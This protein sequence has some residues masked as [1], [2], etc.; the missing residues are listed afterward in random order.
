LSLPP[1]IVHAPYLT[2]AARALAADRAGS[3]AASRAVRAIW[4][5]NHLA[6]GIE[7]LAGQVP[8]SK[9]PEDLLIAIVGMEAELLVTLRC[10]RVLAHAAGSHL[11][12]SARERLAGLPGGDP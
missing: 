11:P 9:A 2:P 5:I 10:A 12:D 6:H 7:V 1:I 3:R 8:S 4:H